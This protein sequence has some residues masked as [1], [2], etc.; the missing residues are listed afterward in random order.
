MFDLDSCVGFITN[1][2]AKKLAE[3]FNNKLLPLG[4][5]RVQWI[6]MY[7]LDKHT[8]LSQIEL[9]EK[10]D[11]KPS[12]MARLVDRLERDGYAERAK[13]PEDRRM[14]YVTL[15]NKGRIFWKEILPAGEKMGDIF[16]KDICFEDLE[17]FKKVLNKM[18][19]NIQ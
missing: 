1:R 11:I 4:V 9:A 10:M 7:Y 6:A 16:S 3:A 14:F 17:I 13:A 12:S 5:T 19:E 18:V 15:T 8:S 2:Q